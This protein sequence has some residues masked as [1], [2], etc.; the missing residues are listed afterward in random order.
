MTWLTVTARL[1]GLHGS[2]RIFQNFAVVIVDDLA[3]ILHALVTHL[4]IVLDD[5]F[6][7][8]V[9]LWKRFY[10][11]H[12]LLPDLCLHACAEWRIELGDLSRPRPVFIFF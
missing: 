5:Q 7:E 4:D 11:F 8:R 2:D 1:V 10:N 12:K 6:G 9:V 3:H